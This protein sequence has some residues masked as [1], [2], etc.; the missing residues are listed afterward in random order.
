MHIVSPATGTAIKI[1]LSS[2]TPENII[3]DAEE[4]GFLR[5]DI[6]V[7]EDLCASWLWLCAVEKESFSCFLF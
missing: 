7:A 3:S 5:L 1:I 6:A 4:K 2:C